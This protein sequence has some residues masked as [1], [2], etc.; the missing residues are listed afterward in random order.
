[1]L[2]AG[3]IGGTKTILGIY[4]RDAGPFAPLRE[5]TFP[6]RRYGDFAELI[7]EFR[8]RASAKAG[9]AVF[10]VAGPVLGRNASVT[11]LPWTIRAA[12]LART[13]NLRSVLLLNDTEAIAAAVPL[14]RGEDLL[15]IQEGEAAPGGTMAVIAP[16]T[17]LGEAFLTRECR[18]CRA[19]ASEGGHADFAPADDLQIGLLKYLLRRYGHVSWER[20]CSGSGIPDIYDY[21]KEAG[22]AA[23]SPLPAEEFARTEDRTPFIVEAAL[24]PAGPCPLCRGTLEMFVSILGAEAGNLALKIMATGGVYLGGGIPPRLAGILGRGPF[25]EA[26]RRKGRFSRFMERIPVHVILNPKAALLGAAARGLDEWG[27]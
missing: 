18:N 27:G 19:H 24:D 26:F 10:A 14:L 13:L 4:S 15:T 21:L 8:G 20:V 3:D 11:N 12:E 23:Q 17:G 22:C 6:S 5:E 2:I 16:G 9:H 25:L 1:M 7:A